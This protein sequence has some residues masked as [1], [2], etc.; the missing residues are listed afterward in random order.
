MSDDDLGLFIEGWTSEDDDAVANAEFFLESDSE[1][2]NA[3]IEDRVPVARARRPISIADT[4][5]KLALHV[6]SSLSAEEKYNQI[7]ASLRHEQQNITFH[8]LP[9]ALNLTTL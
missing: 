3:F 6:W 1:S 8:K 9:N 2:F 7:A 4:A 5:A